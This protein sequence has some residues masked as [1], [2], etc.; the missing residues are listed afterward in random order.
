MASALDSSPGTERFDGYS[1]ELN[2]VTADLTQKLDTLPS[3]PAQD[4]SSTTSACDRLL[5]E[6]SELLTSMKM[7]KASV[8][9]DS[10]QKI[11]QRL[12]NHESDVDSLKRRLATLNSDKAKLF[13]SRY[14]DDPEMGFGDEQQEQRQQLLSGTD[15]LNRSSQRLRDSQ[16]IANET[17]QIGAGTLADL[18]QQRTQL[19]GTRERL[20]ESEGYT[21]RSIKTLRGMARR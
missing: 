10:K 5:D 11:A 4:R 21:D 3:L 13:G 9:T 12:R 6:A 20:L 8:P 7:E 2:L 16:R 14:R 19:E 1:A 18:A 17:E 15:R